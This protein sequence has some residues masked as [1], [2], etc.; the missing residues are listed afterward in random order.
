MYVNGK[1]IDSATNKDLTGS[2]F[3]QGGA[4]LVAADTTDPTAVAYTNALVWI[5][6]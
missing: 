2:T 3:K 1:N 6:S 5:A 4:G